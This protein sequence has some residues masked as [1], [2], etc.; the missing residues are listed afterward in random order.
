ME[1]NN[2]S[3]IKTN[4]FINNQIKECPYC[5]A[6]IPLSEYDDHIF[7]HQ[8]DGQENGD[9]GFNINNYGL[10][11]NNNNSSL[12]NNISS[13][14]NTNNN[15][16]N[17][18]NNNNFNNN[19][20]NNNQNQ[21]YINPIYQG[22]NSINV[23]NDNNNNQNNQNNQNIQ[24]NQNNQNIQNNINNDNNKQESFIDRIKN[25]L[26]P[27]KNNN[28]NQSSRDIMNIP[29]E[30][31]SPEELEE[32]NKIEEQR[33]Y[34]KKILGIASSE[35]QAKVED[36]RST[37]EKITQFI[38][39]NQN[40]IFATID[41]IGC[42]TL[43]TPSIGRTILRVSNLIGDQYN[44]FVNNRNSENNESIGTNEYDNIIRE[45]PELKR[46]DKDPD[47]IIKFLPVS[48]VK[49]I[50]NQDNNNNNNNNK[51][52][53]CLSEFELGD[54]VSA[55]PC[56]H[57]FHTECIASWIKKHCQCPV[58]KFNVTLKSLIGG[59]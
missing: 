17:L 20:Q 51:C 4:E 21:P 59:V 23:I 5:N 28:N 2:F 27:S 53:I 38:Q 19:N 31:L 22:L 55:L 57:V 6:I 37:G 40:A 36:N 8:V 58:C 47:T 52:I 24:N 1:S 33:A 7:C 46:K 14:N 50:R 10:E 44:N 43:H 39:N 42:L 11:L 49:E 18:M 45:H 26:I 34:E 56:A 35:S 41:I 54:Q 13:N 16:N 9:Q 29:R 15:S 25:Y 32:R 48:E 30:N 12:S 3:S